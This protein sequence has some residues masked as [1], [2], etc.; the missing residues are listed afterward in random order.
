MTTTF[1]NVAR[2][3]LPKP[4]RFSQM[5]YSRILPMIKRIVDKPTIRITSKKSSP[6][7]N[8]KVERERSKNK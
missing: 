5:H 2:P 1:K 6:I 7:N 3:A 8:Q 4:A